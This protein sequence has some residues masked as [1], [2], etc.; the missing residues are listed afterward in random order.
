MHGKLLH[1]FL[2]R[3]VPAEPY[4]RVDLKP[5]VFKVLDDRAF[6]LAGMRGRTFDTAMEDP[7]PYCFSAAGSGD[8]ID[9]GH[10]DVDMETVRRELK[11]YCGEDDAIERLP[12]VEAILARR[13]PL[14]EQGMAEFR[15]AGFFGANDPLFWHWLD[16]SKHG[17][18]F[19]SAPW[20]L[21]VG[22]S[23]ALAI[24]REGTWF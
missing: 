5:V 13:D 18:G 19:I 6:E 15:A 23:H 9:L 20:I 12:K 1:V 21:F 10:F 4:H 14:L 24:V 2:Y 22:K 7:Q 16:D 11:D 3:V 8:P 17:H